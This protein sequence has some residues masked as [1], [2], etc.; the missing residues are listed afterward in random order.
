MRNPLL[1][2]LLSCCTTALFAQQ[3]ADTKKT[4]Y[5]FN[6]H[7]KPVMTIGEATAFEVVTQQNDTT[8]IVRYYKNY[9]SMLWQKTFKDSSLSL[10]NGRFAWYDKNGIIDSTG[11]M[12]N[13]RKDGLWDYFLDSSLKAKIIV[14][15]T[16]NEEHK[17]GKNAI[18]YVSTIKSVQRFFKNGVLADN[19]DEAIGKTS[20]TKWDYR[21]LNHFLKKNLDQEIGKNNSYYDNAGYNNAVETISFKVLK[22]NSLSDLYILR[23]CGFPYDN[24][25]L[26]TIQRSPKWNPLYPDDKNISVQKFEKIIFP[27]QY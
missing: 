13:G 22:D 23:S 6:K 7:D 24:N 14:T 25:L 5:L 4:F 26:E 8:Y 12:K 2:I 19:D 11:F 21:N 9:G 27:Y 20:A 18:Q 15:L 10:P 17:I 1:F 3:R 16:K